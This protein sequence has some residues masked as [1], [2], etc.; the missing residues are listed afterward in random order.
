[1]KSRAHIEGR[2]H[3]HANVAE[4]YTLVTSMKALKCHFVVDHRPK[5]LNLAVNPAPPPPPK[6]KKKNY[7]CGQNP[8]Q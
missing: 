1:M 3:Q 5:M 8:Y 2:Q 4:G 6:K 7:M